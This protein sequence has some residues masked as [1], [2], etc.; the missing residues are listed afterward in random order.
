M[1]NGILP[2]Q[3][4]SFCLSW[5]SMYPTQKRYWP[6]KPFRRVHPGPT[7]SAP[8][9]LSLDDLKNWGWEGTFRE[10]LDQTDT[11]PFILRSGRKARARQRPRRNTDLFE[12]MSFED[13]PLG[14]LYRGDQE[15]SFHKSVASILQPIRVVL[16]RKVLPE[17]GTSAFPSDQTSHQDRLEKE[18]D[19]L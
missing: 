13:G 7:L 8:S 3:P 1:G 11:L 9:G 15:F 6:K 5:K 17:K 4:K 2:S 10:R 19:I 14:F 18:R 16:I 12:V